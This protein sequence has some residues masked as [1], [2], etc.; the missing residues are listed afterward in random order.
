MLKL[1]VTLILFTLSTSILAENFVQL[2][3]HSNL[4]GTNE[5]GNLNIFANGQVELSRL[6]IPV[7]IGNP[8]Q[9]LNLEINTVGSDTWVISKKCNT[10]YCRGEPIS[11]DYKRTQYDVEA[12]STGKPTGLRYNYPNL[13]NCSSVSDIFT[14]GNLNIGTQQFGENQDVVYS[15]AN[16]HIDGYLGLGL[17]SNGVVKFPP[18]IQ[19]LTKLDNPEFTIFIQKSTFNGIAGTFTVGRYDDQHCSKDINHVHT[20]GLIDIWQIPVQKMSVGTEAVPNSEATALLSLYEN[21]IVIPKDK[22]NIVIKH[23]NGYYD[24]RAGTYAVNCN[25]KTPVVFNING[26]DQRIESSQYKVYVRAFQSCYLLFTP[27]QNNQNYYI[28]GKPFFRSFCLNFNVAKQT[29]GIALSK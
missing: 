20:E 12:S 21:R 1:I 26:K 17:K 25:V 15:V 22:F 28:F 27:L 3:I 13:K 6:T 11:R 10:T 2:P 5:N 9:T 8:A 24:S 4:V 23:L 19:T 14:I 7:A 16:E 18:F 29:V